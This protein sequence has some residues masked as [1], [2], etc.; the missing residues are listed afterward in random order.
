MTRKRL[1]GVMDKIRLITDPLPKG[2]IYPCTI[3]DIQ[4]K[5]KTLPPEMLRSYPPFTCATRNE[6]GDAHIYD[7]ATFASTC[8]RKA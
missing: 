1:L 8:S 6:P 2:Y 5:L 3:Q 7:G 4:E